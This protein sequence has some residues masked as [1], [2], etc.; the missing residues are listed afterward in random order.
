MIWGYQNINLAKWIV[1]RRV[2]RR[3]LKPGQLMP[4]RRGGLSNKY[5]N[6]T[7]KVASNSNIIS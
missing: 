3:E 4:G 7:S 5:N 1:K 6:S 2:V